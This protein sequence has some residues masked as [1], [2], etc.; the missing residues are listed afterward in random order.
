MLLYELGTRGMV[1]ELGLKELLKVGGAGLGT[2]HVLALL[3][4]S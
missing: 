1:C 4:N 3:W 2:A